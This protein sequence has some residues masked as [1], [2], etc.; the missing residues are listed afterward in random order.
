[1]KL[2]KITKLDNNKNLV[3]LIKKD[4][5]LNIYGLSEVEQK[6]AEKQI[7]DD[8]KNV[9]IN[10]Y[11]RKIFIQ[12]FDEKEEDKIYKLKEKFRKAA[13]TICGKLNADK[14]NEVQIIS[15]HST[16]LTFVF[17]EALVLSNH[18]YLKYF[19]KDLDKKTNTLDTINVLHNNLKEEDF[20]EIKNITQGVFATRNLVNEIPAEL[21]SIK[22]AE[23]LKALSKQA[24]FE[25]EVFNKAKIES[26]KM[27]G[28]LAVNRASNYE[29]TFSIMTWKPKNAKNK[30]PIV[31]VGKG[32]VYDTGG[33]SL[34]PS[35]YMVEMKS[36]M[37]GA[38]T[39][40]GIIYA[41]AKQKL[42]LYV[43]AL[44]PSTDNA[45]NNKA[46]VPD[47]VIKMHNG[48]TVEIGNTDA[49]GRLI[50]ADALSYAQKYDP[51]LVFDFATLTG[52]AVRAVGNEAI[53]IMGTAQKETFKNVE[54]AGRQTYERTIQ[55][56][57]WDEY[58]EQIKS[59]IA[60]IKNIGGA[61]AGQIT[62]GKFLE[63]FTNYPWI[64]FDIAGTAYL[65]K[66]K[67]YAG[68]GGTGSA[69]RLVYNFLKKY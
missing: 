9:E 54:C 61:Y 29:P 33:M 63:H 41:V 17:V 12:I 23:E 18:Q 28:L 20:S 32:I 11:T 65:P 69:V 55:F 64:H 6:F 26:L 19:T 36:D 1:M 5:K 59:K 45:V 27:G 35:Q 68:T 7:E 3:L 38:A 8:K 15:L 40:A 66:N 44:A 37:A 49:E 24:G 58:G 34:K 39:V 67:S 31:L 60:D 50:L 42:P 48:M 13:Y 46:Y 21:T 4:S 62:A 56:P 47:D 10:Q 52:A 2:Q 22:L 25:I 53:A 51:E 30:K 14:I 16:E 57:L 43:I